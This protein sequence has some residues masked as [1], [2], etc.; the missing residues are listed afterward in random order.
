MV[1][2]TNAKKLRAVLADNLKRLADARHV[3]VADVAR[4]LHIADTTVRNWFNGVK[5]PRID[6]V[7][8][9]AD[10]FHVSRSDITD[11][12]PDNMF[13]IKNVTSIPIIGEIACGDP[14]MAEEN[15]DGY[16]DVVSSHVPYG[17]I[18]YLRAKGH[19]MEPTIPDGSYVMVREQPEVEDGQIAAVLVDD[20]EEATI[21]RVRHQ[22]NLIVLM[23]DNPDYKPIVL[24]KEY[25]GRIIG[26]AI[27]VNFDL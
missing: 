5:Y 4:D 6:K 16:R 1:E 7:Q 13:P 19:S 9:L 26:R 21:K 15:I 14:I 8:A 3:T 20:D 23:P 17:N 11:S 25:P 2:K 27:E 18:F 12:Q 22:G 24:S 10:Y